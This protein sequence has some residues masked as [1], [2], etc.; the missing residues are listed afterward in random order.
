MIVLHNIVDGDIAGD[1]THQGGDDTPPKFYPPSVVRLHQRAREG[2]DGIWDGAGTTA[3]AKGAKNKIF[4]AA[5]E[6]LPVAARP[7]H[8]TA[9]P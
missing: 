9:R 4:L 2:G 8:L 5:A 6:V 3:W 1:R 7:L